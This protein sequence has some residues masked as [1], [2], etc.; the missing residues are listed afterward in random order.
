MAVDLGDLVESVQREVNPPGGT[1]FPDATEDDYLGFLQ[2]AFWETTLDGLIEGYTEADGLVTP[3]DGDTDLSR[4]MQQLVVIY[5]GFKMLKNYLTN[6]NTTFRA[7]AG[8]VEFETQ[9]SAALLTQLM[10]DLMERRN[11]ILARLSELGEVPSYY[12]DSVIERT[13]SNFYGDVWWVKG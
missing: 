5:A 12:Y 7:V 13:S 11:S 6:V 4:E 8:P 10:K 3:T 9:Q 1:I 2:D